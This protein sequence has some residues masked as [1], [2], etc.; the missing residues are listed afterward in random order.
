MIHYRLKLVQT[1]FLNRSD[2]FEPI[3]TVLKRFRISLN[4]NKLVQTGSACNL[5]QNRPF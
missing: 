2:R 3:G 1:G 4:R 5:N